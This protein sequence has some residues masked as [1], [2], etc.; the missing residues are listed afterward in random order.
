MNFK[1]KMFYFISNQK[2][3][4]KFGDLR[5]FINKKSFK[6]ACGT[7]ITA[8]D[9]IQNNQIKLEWSIELFEG[10]TYLHSINVVHRDINPKY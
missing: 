9:Y 6:T 2:Q 7:L 10:L 5:H 1:L 3:K 8:Q 4:N